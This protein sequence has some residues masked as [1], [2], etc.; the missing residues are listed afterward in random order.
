M[1]LRPF[2]L[3]SHLLAAVATWFVVGTI[4]SPA[5]PAEQNWPNWRGPLANGVAPAATPPLTWS[6]TNN[7]KWKVPIPGVGQA[8]PIIW[9]DR[10]FLLTAV[11]TGRQP[12]VLQETVTSSTNT[13]GEARTRERRMT[14]QPT[15]VYQFVLLCLDRESGRTLWQRVANELLPHEGYYLNNAS[16][17]SGSAVTD[18]QHVFAY[19]GSRGLYCYDLRG[20]L[21][22]EK[23]LG[24]MQ[25]HEGFGEGSSPAL[26]GNTVVVTWDH[27]GDDF[28][29]ALDKTTGREL[30]RQPRDEYASWATPF[31]VQH[32]ARTE[33]VTPATAKARSYDLATGELLWECSGLGELAIPTPVTGHGMVYLMTG[34]RESSL[35]AIRLGR[36]GDLTGTDAIV[37][38]LNRN[39]PYVASPMLYGD[40]LYILKSRNGILSCYDARTGQPHYEEERLEGLSAVWASPVAAADRVY[41]MSRNGTAVVIRHSDRLEV[42]AT[43]KLEDGDGF[44]ASPALVGNQIFIRGPKHLY[45][46]E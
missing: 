41:H 7:I 12:E 28:I 38:S 21:K 24:Q 42:L 23:A 4:P 15:E 43:N 19:F 13:T 9:D 2:L 32:G 5:A 27:T 3:G 33:V 35:L 11:N 44:D 14:H 40:R 45:C 36:S 34:Y 16:F 20:N 37:W 17:A 30:W 29:V 22:W 31:I 39:T 26:W 1:T 8:S 25:V 18:G 6:E 10:I 46:I